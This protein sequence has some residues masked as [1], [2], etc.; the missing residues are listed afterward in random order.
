MKAFCAWMNERSRLVKI[1][2][3]LPIIDILWGLYRLFGAIGDKNI[4]R[5]VLAIVWIIF[6]GFIGWVLDL[7]CIILT[8]HI[9][10]FKE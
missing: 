4:L 10:W 2:F 9:F 7:I 3:C 6:G 8:G 5:L 1:L